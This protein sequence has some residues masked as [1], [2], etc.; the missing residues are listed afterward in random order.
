MGSQPRQYHKKIWINTV[1]QP[2]FFSSNKIL[3][4]NKK[5]WGDL[6]LQM[7]GRAYVYIHIYSSNEFSQTQIY[8]RILRWIVIRG[9]QLNLKRLHRGGRLNLKI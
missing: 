7:V 9:E 3:V 4:L 8:D 1:H 2:T 6:Q 5:K